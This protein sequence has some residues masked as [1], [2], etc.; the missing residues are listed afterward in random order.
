M[1]RSFP[2]FPLIFSIAYSVTAFADENDA[3]DWRL[4]KKGTEQKPIKVVES[5]KTVEKARSAAIDTES[6]EFGAYTG[7]LS[8]EDFNTNPVVGVSLS[9][10]V[11][12]RFLAQVNYGQSNVERATFEDLAGGNFVAD[13]EDTFEYYNVLAGFKILPGRSF[14]GKTRKYN[15]DIYLFV[16][17]GNFEFAGNEDTN[18][19]IGASYRI[20]VTDWLTWNIDFRDHFMDREFL[21][22]DKLTHNLEFSLGLNALF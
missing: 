3:I 21:S 19:V 7:M 9:Y 11:T 6:F 10:H 16:G 14:L 12:N 1:L 13:D 15:S 2:L 20:V 5:K 18:L 4:A 8:V 17:V 22:E